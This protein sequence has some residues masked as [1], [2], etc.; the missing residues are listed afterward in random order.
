MQAQYEEEIRFFSQQTKTPQNHTTTPKA[1]QQHKTPHHTHHHFHTQKNT[2]TKKKIQ[3]TAHQH[4]RNTQTHTQHK[5]QHST[6]HSTAHNKKRQKKGAIRES[7]PWPLA[8]EARIIPL[9]QSPISSLQSHPVDQ[10]MGC[11]CCV[12]CCVVP[13]VCC[14]VPRVCCVCLLRLCCACVATREHK[15]TGGENSRGLW[16][17]R[18]NSELGKQK[19]RGRYGNRTRGLLHPK[20]ESYP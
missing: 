10:W 18:E 5:T 13:R 4:T 12:L 1:P 20:Q 16:R 17:H 7:N 19:K 2:Q 3:R 6:K 9:D 15:G 14:V 8:P 11:C